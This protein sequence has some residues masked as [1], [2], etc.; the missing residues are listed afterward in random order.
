MGAYI[1]QSSLH[2]TIHA[3]IHDIPTPNGNVCKR[4]YI[5][6]IRREKAGLISLRDDSALKRISF[7]IEMWNDCCPA[8]TAIL[9]WQRNI[10]A[11]FYKK[12][13]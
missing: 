3:K 10:I 1:P 11:K 13:P 12:T 6:L 7:L 4:T 8:T 5:E 2:A 9:I